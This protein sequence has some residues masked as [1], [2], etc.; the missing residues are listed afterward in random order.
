MIDIIYILIAVFFVVFVKMVI[1]NAKAESLKKEAK[2]EKLFNTSP[3]IT[4][5]ENLVNE[6]PEAIQIIRSN[7]DGSEFVHQIAEGIANLAP[8][9]LVA[10]N[11]RILRINKSK[12]KLFQLSQKTLVK[13]L[14]Y[15]EIS[16]VLIIK[17]ALFSIVTIIPK[18]GENVEL[19]IFNGYLAEAFS[20][21]VK[22]QLENSVN[23]INDTSTQPETQMLRIGRNGEDIGEMTAKKVKLL[24]KSGQLELT[25][26]YWDKQL[27]EWIPLSSCEAII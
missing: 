21:F 8:A 11:K 22:G 7:L 19:S 4:I 27:N 15:S 12:I 23:P 10:T 20:E 2:G 24:L 9:V 13:T 1:T 18:N 17:K 3:E 16:N 26:F 6:F 5:P 25:D 14:N